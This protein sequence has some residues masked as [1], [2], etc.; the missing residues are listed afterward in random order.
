MSLG[1]AARRRVALYGGAAVFAALALW[2]IPAFLSRLAPG[3]AV[4]RMDVEADAAMETEAVKLLREYVRID[5]SNPPGRTRPAIEFL[6]RI[7]GC[8][9]IPV[10]VTGADPERP[11]LVARLKGRTPTGRSRFT[12]TR[13]SF[14]PEIPRRGRSRRSRPSAAMAPRA[15]TSTG[16]ERST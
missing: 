14:R 10:T 9:G 16:G 4:R 12:T 1:P 8:E 13:T 11:I 6:A 3:V 15:T 7:L 5:T 2:A